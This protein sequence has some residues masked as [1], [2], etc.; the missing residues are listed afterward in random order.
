VGTAGDIFITLIIP[1]T[2]DNDALVLIVA[3]VVRGIDDTSIE[4][5]ALIVS[6]TGKLDT[7]GIHT[8][9]VMD[10]IPEGRTFI[11]SGFIEDDALVVLVTDAP[12]RA[13]AVDER[14]TFTGG[15]TGHGYA[16]I[17]VIACS[18]RATGDGVGAF[19]G[20]LFGDGNTLIALITD[21]VRFST[22]EE[23]VA[24]VIAGACNDQTRGTIFRTLRVLPAIE[25]RRALIAAGTLIHKTH[26]P[27]IITDKMLLSAIGA[28]DACIGTI[29]G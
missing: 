15:C 17:L 19:V 2:I 26:A 18:V 9:K 29:A 4:G 23:G 10:A 14:I 20:T 6:W 21:G 13:A 27:W 8:C 3:F 11:R 24:V 16:L 12:L 7:G 28:I 22:G 5:I 25:K 1:C